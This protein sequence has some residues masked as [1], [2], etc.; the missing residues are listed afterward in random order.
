MSPTFRFF[1]I[2]LAA[3]FASTIIGAC[4]AAP[5]A[6]SSSN[7]PP[8]STPSPATGDFFDSTG[9][10]I[11]YVVDRPSGNGPFPGIVI[12][13]EGG[14]VTKGDLAVQAA[15]LTQQ[16]FIVLRYDKRGT[17]FSTGTFEEVT[18][19]N[20]VQR[21]GL[22]AADMAAAVQTL[23][24]VSGVNTAKIGLVGVSQAGWV[25]PLAATLS[26]DVKFIAA[27]VGPA[28]PVGPLY[29]YAGQATDPS[30]D[31]NTLSALLAAYNGATGFDPRP[32][33]QQLSIPML[34]LMATGDRVVPTRESVAFL[35]TLTAAGKPVTVIQYAGGHE[36]RETTNF[37]ADLF[38]WLALRK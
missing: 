16:G 12:G 18:T 31:F 25:M 5:A 29:Y 35:N 27:V 20:S 30:K 37:A 33:L 32:S 8:D 36:L 6:P 9:A 3:A 11:S 38:A 7:T 19:E 21:I 14:V 2:A 17:G 22:L 15:A 26:S 23:K 13:H 1:R 4:G 34:Y 10:R 28:V 24:T